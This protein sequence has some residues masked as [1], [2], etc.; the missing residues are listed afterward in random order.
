MNSIM[1]NEPKEPD[2]I[3]EPDELEEYQEQIVLALTPYLHAFP[4]SK[5]SDEG[6]VIYAKALSTLTL[7]QIH[8]AMVKILRNANF[9]PTIA[10]ILREV[11]NIA[12]FLK[13]IHIPTAGEA[14]QEVME[15]AKKHHIFEEWE[16][17]YPAIKKAAEFFGTYELCT[18]LEK[19][20]NIARSQFMRIYEAILQREKEQKEYEDTCAC[21]PGEIIQELTQQLSMPMLSLVPPSLKPKQIISNTT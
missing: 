1:K 17:T 4:H 15:N 8:I 13:G 3:D 16:Y 19:D 18:I 20:V 5:I 6:L 21:L 2:E 14:W 9:F 11:D 12:N 7:P 10:E